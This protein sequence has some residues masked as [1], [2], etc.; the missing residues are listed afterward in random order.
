MT[1]PSSNQVSTDEFLPEFDPTRSKFP[2]NNWSEKIVRCA[3]ISSVNLGIGDCLLNNRWQVNCSVLKNILL[4]ICF[5]KIE[6]VER[7]QN[8]I[9]QEMNY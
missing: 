4:K 9:Y 2:A 6:K 7:R 3:S 5:M 8:Q 1:Q